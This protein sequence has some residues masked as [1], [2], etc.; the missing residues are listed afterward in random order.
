[1]N[2]S[3]VRSIGLLFVVVG[4]IPAASPYVL[5]CIYAFHMPLFFFLAGFSVGED[6][7]RHPI[8]AYLR[9]A[10]G[11]YLVP[12]FVFFLISFL[13][14]FAGEIL[15]SSPVSSVQ[16]LFGLLYGNLASLVVN[17]VLWF[18]PAIFSVTLLYRLV[19]GSLKAWPAV[20]L[21]F[22]TALFVMVL[23]DPISAPLPWGVD[24][25]LV[26]TF[27]Y[28]VGHG[29]RTC[30]SALA[31]LRSHAWLV[32]ISG[33]LAVMLIGI[34]NGKPNLARLQFGESNVLY[35][36][37]AFSGIIATLALASLIR[38]NQLFEWIGR[39]G[40]V[41]FPLHTLFFALITAIGRVGFHLP[42]KFQYHGFYWVLVYAIGSL[43]L[44]YPA[45]RMFNRFAPVL[46]GRKPSAS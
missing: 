24:V 2:L 18:L 43:A 17:P 1:M 7:I 39:S 36:C 9:H 34:W 33:T 45:E 15:K 19:R 30:D 23:P 46:I 37:G 14:W 42:P 41:I 27:F 25:A 31:W 22:F 40:M 20:G 21:F 38:P 16:A 32:T 8:G 12:Y 6:K 10:C 28:A 5:K 11:H 29:A 26:A 35:F 3:N 4:H 13:V 44:C